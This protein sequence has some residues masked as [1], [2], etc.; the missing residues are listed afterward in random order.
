MSILDTGRP[1]AGA[2][3]F[4][5]AIAA[6]FAGLASWNVTRITR[7]RL[8]RLGDHELL[9]IGLSRGDIERLTF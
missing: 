4:L 6:L 2:V 1:A 8:R 7:R 5:H 3:P 9:D